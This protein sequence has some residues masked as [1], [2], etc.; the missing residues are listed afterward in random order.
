MDESHAPNFASLHL[1]VT[2]LIWYINDTFDL[3]GAPP[4]AQSLWA[5]I[6]SL[7]LLAEG[8]V[9]RGLDFNCLNGVDADNALRLLSATDSA[10]QGL[11][12]II[13]KL[14]GDSFRPANALA[15]GEEICDQYYS[16]LQ[17][18]RLQ[19]ANAMNWLQ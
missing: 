17:S 3:S 15:V 16:L 6:R 1:S 18:S 2:N 14:Q 11:E 12:T 10:V 4:R 5:E 9:R 8:A 19:L 7:R 13:R